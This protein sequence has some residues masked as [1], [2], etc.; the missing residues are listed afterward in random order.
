M[1]LNPQSAGI[2]VVIQSPQD[3]GAL[4][5]RTR[6]A[7]GLSQKEVAGIGRTGNRV[8]VDIESG[9]PTVQLQKVL[10]LLDLLGLQLTVKTKS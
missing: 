7:Q 6:K 9:K 10:D 2:D 8:I 5:R 1:S 3:L 4:I